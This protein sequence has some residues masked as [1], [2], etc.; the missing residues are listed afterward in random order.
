M[1]GGA[2]REIY[3]YR[4]D[5]DFTQDEATWEYSVRMTL[6]PSDGEDYTV[7]LMNSESLYPLLIG[8]LSSTDEDGSYVLSTKG[9]GAKSSIESMKLLDKRTVLIRQGT[10]PIAEGILDVLES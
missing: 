9:E 6:T 4:L 8:K 5:Q 7:W 1:G 2:V 10:E 3:A